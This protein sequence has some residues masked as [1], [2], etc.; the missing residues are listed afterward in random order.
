MYRIQ[1]IPDKQVI[2]K[3]WAHY[4]N[5]HNKFF[6]KMNSQIDQEDSYAFRRKIFKHIWNKAA[7]LKDTAKP[8]VIK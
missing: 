3:K 6:P 1:N 5:N 4:Y 8:K 2:K 7:D